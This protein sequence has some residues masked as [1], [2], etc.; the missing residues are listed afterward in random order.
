M[1]VD[2]E[3][4]PGGEPERPVKRAGGRRPPEN[5][6]STVRL[7]GRTREAKAAKLFEAELVR[8]VGGSPSAT[9]AALI[10]Q[11]TQIQ[12]RLSA[13]DE[14][15]AERGDQSAHDSRVYLSWANSLSRLMRQIG[16]KGGAAKG[17]S[18]SEYIAGR[19]AGAKATTP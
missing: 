12:M 10:A 18:L 3:M 17:P 5:L 19:A 7:D 8:H 13:M 14:A 6:R 11:A 15:F 1:K 2:A 9:Q 4:L 16:L